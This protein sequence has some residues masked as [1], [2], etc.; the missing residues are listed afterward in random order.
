MSLPGVWGWGGVH[1]TKGQ[2]AQSSTKLGHDM[3][4]PGWWCTSDQSSTEVGHKMSLPG[5]GWGGVEWGH[6]GWG[7][8]MGAG[9]GMGMRVH[10]TK[11]QPHLKQFQTWS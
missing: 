10:L 9:V 5:M 4:L 7:H 1:L 8:G 3:S 11:C 6:G 2:P